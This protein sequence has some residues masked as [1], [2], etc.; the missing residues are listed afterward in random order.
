[1]SRTSPRPKAPAHF[2][3]KAKVLWKKLNEQFEFE[4]DAVQTLAVGLE[5]LDLA[6]KARE[7]LRAEG[8]VVAGKRHPAA[9]IAKQ[10]DGMYLRALRQL[11][12][13]VVQAGEPK[14]KRV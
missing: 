3:A 1:M 2:S 12:L 4:P 9:D 13:D 11:A 5:N 6:D 8:V 10:C 7:L 14:G